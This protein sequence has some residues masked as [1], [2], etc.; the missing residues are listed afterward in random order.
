MYM[1]KSYNAPVALIE[2]SGTDDTHL[3]ISWSDTESK[4]MF[5]ALTLLD[6]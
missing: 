1:L 4:A 2:K 6:E 3:A 5:P